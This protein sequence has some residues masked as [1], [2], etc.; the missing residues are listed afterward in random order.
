MRSFSLSAGL[1][2][3]CLASTAHAAGF[4]IVTPPDDGATYALG[5]SGDGQV[6]VGQLSSGGNVTA[7]RYTVTEGMTDLGDIPGGSVFASATAASFDGSVIVGVSDAA[8]T[9]NVSGTAQVAFRWTKE[10]G[11][12]ELGDLPG[13]T[14]MAFAQGVSADGLIVA[15]ASYPA[16]DDF[17]A[18]R[19][20]LGQSVKSLGSFPSL[21]PRGAAYGVSKDGDVIVGQ[22]L[23]KLDDGENNRAFR[24][25]PALGLVDIGDL[26][27]GTT[28][29]TAT[30]VSADGLVVVGSSSSV[31][32]GDD[33]LEAFRYVE[34]VGMKG[35]GDLPG[36]PFG[37][38]ALAVNGDGSVVVGRSIIDLDENEAAFYWTENGGMQRLSDVA[39][40]AGID[41]GGAEL[42]QATGVS[43]DG[44]VVVGIA[45]IPKGIAAFR[46]DLTGTTSSS[47][48]SSSGT[49]GTGGSTSSSTG[50]GGTGGSGGSASSSTGGTGGATS[51]TT[52]SGTT[53]STS[54]GVGGAGG[55]GGAGGESPASSGD[56]GC[57]TGSTAPSDVSMGMAAFA[58]LAIARRRKR[59][60]R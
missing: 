41:L 20:E 47:S 9:V 34:G 45:L 32:S 38:E 57:R 12:V 55:G 53:S 52:S 17:E 58:A 7:L 27:G 48:S 15:G 29:A 25:T 8:S 50:T 49:G 2:A 5:V 30:G 37:S 33:Y 11:F 28:Y 3:L 1:A 59:T 21:T 18:C 40:A 22:S 51:S 46:L 35:L 4:Q 42:R 43:A 44:L 24:W 36:G 60:A 39:A 19:W 54:T 13:G 14:A 31:S 23:H 10:T 26:P 6:L 56:C 16:T